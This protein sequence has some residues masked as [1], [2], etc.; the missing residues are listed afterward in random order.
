MPSETDRA[1]P[2]YGALAGLL[3][4]AVA[5]GVGQLVASIGAQNSSPLVAVGDAA[6]GLAPEPVKNFAITEF[7]S[8]DKTVLLIGIGVVLAIF[9]AVI[10]VARRVPP[11]LRARR[12][13]RLRRRRPGR[14]RHPSRSGRRILRPDPGR[15]RGERVHAGPAAAHHPGRQHQAGIRSGRGYEPPACPRQTQA[16]ARRE[17]VP[18]R[19]GLRPGHRRARGFLVTGV[20]A[21][22]TTV[23]GVL[24]GRVLAER[25]AVTQA[26]AVAEAA[27]PRADGG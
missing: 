19:G 23:V 20:V 24:A 10:G 11:G 15:G 27:A 14:R 25:G 17:W 3:T 21:A 26:R 8:H 2:L 18:D 5:V 9:A 12:A 1:R 16:P 22:A 7:G 13:R 6:I 4:G